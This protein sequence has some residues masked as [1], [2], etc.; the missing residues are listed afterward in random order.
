MKLR[1]VSTLGLWAIV[2][3]LPFL[4]DWMGHPHLGGVI[5]IVLAAAL[6]QLELHEI[7][8]KAGLEGDRLLVVGCGL[9]MTIGGYYAV[10]AGTS[11]G[12]LAFFGMLP[13]LLVPLLWPRPDAFMPRVAANLFNLFFVAF[14][15]SFGLGFLLQDALLLGVWAIAAA[16]FADVGALLAGKFFG[17]TLFAPETSPKKTW[18][19]VV[20]G[21]LTSVAV[22]VCFQ[23]FFADALPTAFTPFMAAIL[24]IP[25]AMAGIAGDLLESALKRAAG[26]KD[27][28]TLIPG[29]GGVFDVTDS[30]VLALPVGYL[31][32]SGL[33]G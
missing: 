23:L 13:C 12:A 16:K 7:L 11:W 8:K 1:I 10:R 9:F 18:E 31:L 3:G 6:T 24:A 21:L 33:M 32:T 26:V 15:L 17:R 29:I 5:L 22:S 25:V 30:L 19:G 4:T 20:G 27:S 28:G 2:F 14:S